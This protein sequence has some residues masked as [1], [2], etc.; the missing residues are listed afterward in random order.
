MKPDSL[1]PKAINTGSDIG[2]ILFGFSH[3]GRV[4]NDSEQMRLH[5]LRKKKVKNAD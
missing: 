3:L 5:E 2:G 4:P 1:A